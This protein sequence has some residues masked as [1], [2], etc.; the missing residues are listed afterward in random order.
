MTLSAKTYRTFAVRALVALML[1]GSASIGAGPAMASQIKVVVNG[2]PVTSTDIQ[3]RV[4]FLK[5]QRKPANAAAAREELVNEALQAAEMKRIN[6]RVTDSQV[7]Q[8]FARFAASNKLKP[9]QMTQILNQSGV[10]AKHFKEYIRSQIGW[11]QALAA[12]FRAEGAMSREDVVQKM[13]QQGGSKPSATEYMLQQVIFVVPA[14]ERG[15]KLGKRKREAEAMRARFTGC[16]STRSFAKGLVDVTVRELGRVLAPE[17]P[18]EWE[19]QVKAIKP[20]QATTVR[21][22]DRGVEF[23]GVCSTREVSDDRV[24]EMVFNSEGGTDAK[25][26][27][28]SKKYMAEL[29][30]RASIIEK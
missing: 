26:D 14:A 21:E 2:V 23:L 30:K 12:R 13:L 11:N 3:R 8:S 10:T 25:A 24:A 1:G 15:A 29:R 4:A 27:A 17:L 22:T 19:K 5:L 20:G 28:L 7:E 9:A 6:V 16:D 18:P